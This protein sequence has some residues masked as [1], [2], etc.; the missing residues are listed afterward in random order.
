MSFSYADG[1]ITQISTDADPS[2]A[3]G[4]TGVT[5][6][7]YGADP[8]SIIDFGTNRLDIEGDLTINPEDFLLASNA[9]A[10]NAPNG[11]IM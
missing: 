10:A 6:I 4:L 11:A 9:T 3:V 7:T 8:F 2:G 5:D 1:V